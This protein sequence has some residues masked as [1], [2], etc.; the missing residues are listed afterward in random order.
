MRQIDMYLK[1]QYF[2]TKCFDPIQKF[3]MSTRGLTMIFDPIPSTYFRPPP[4]S[5]GSDKLTPPLQVF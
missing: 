4:F 3:G 2:D 1:N 5:S